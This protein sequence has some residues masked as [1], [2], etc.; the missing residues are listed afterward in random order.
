MP[1]VLLCPHGH[2][3]APDPSDPKRPELVC[4]VCGT[5]VLSDDATVVGMRPDVSAGTVLAGT[6]LQDDSGSQSASPGATVCDSNAQSP[7]QSS[8]TLLAKVG[9]ANGEQLDKTCEVSGLALGNAQSSGS[10]TLEIPGLDS[11]GPVDSQ[12]Q[13]VREPRHGHGRRQFDPSATVQ[14]A[15]PSATQFEDLSGRTQAEGAAQAQSARLEATLATPDASAEADDEATG[16]MSWGDRAASQS[17]T[18]SITIPQ[19]R[20][21][22]APKPARESIPGYEIMG[23][24]GRGGMG[25]VYKALQK[26]PNRVVAL[27]MILA[28]GHAEARDLM[29]FRI[30]AEA[31]GRLQ[32]PNIVQVYE[33]GEQD[34]LPYFSLEYVDGGSLLG[35]VAGTPQ[36]ARE[37]AKTVQALAQ[38]MDYAHRRGIMHRD[39]KPANILLT[40][41]G[42]PKITDFGLAK[43][44]DEDASQTRTGAILGTPS[45]MAPEQAA[46]KSKEVGPPADIYALGSI[47]YE[48]LTGRPPF[49]GETVLDT[50]KMVQSAEPL[51]PTRLHA[52]VPRDLETICLKALNK[53][54]HKRYESAGLLAEDL[55]RFLTGEPILARP[56][57]LWEHA[58][59]WTKRRPAVA[60]LIGV[61]TAAV[62]VVSVFGYVLASRE[63]QRAEEAIVLRNAA[64]ERRLEAEVQQNRAQEQTKLAEERRTEAESQRERADKNFQQALAA[65]DAMLTRV[66]EEKLMH[67]PRMEKVRRD[68]LQKALRFYER[69][70]E[71]QGDSLYLLLQTGRA[72]Q[73]VGD[74][75]QL[76]GEKGAA[77]KAFRAAI[78]FFT[79]LTRKLPNQAE[80][81]QEL[82]K[83][84][85]KLSLLLQEIGRRQEADETFQKS[86][87]LKTQLVARYPNTADFRY[88]VA[89]SYQN[90]ALMLQ[91]H[92]ELSGAE[93]DYRRAV[94]IFGQLASD[95][96]EVQSYQQELARTNVNYAVLMHTTNRSRK[97]EELFQKAMDVLVKLVARAP[98]NE[99]FQRELGRV[100]LN[101]GVVK[102]MNGKVV[103]AEKN[104]RAAMETF[105]K[106]AEDFPTVPEYR[107]QLAAA[108]TNL[109]NLL[110]ITNRQEEAEKLV[111]Q[112]LDLQTKLARDFPSVPGY[113]QELARA[114]NDYGILLAGTNRAYQAEDAWSRAISIQ[115]QLASEFPKEPAYRQELGRSHMNF[116]ILLAGQNHL[117]R[118]EQEYRAAVSIQEQLESEAPTV[119]AN[120]EDLLSS[121][122]NLG[123]LL[124]ALGR[125]QDAEKVLLQIAALQERQ[126]ASSPK[127]ARQENALG[128]TLSGLAKLQIEAN[129]LAEARR[130]LQ[131]AIKH[132]RIA[133]AANV[134]NTKYRQELL[135]SYL[136]LV[137]V[138]VQLDEHAEAAQA[139][140]DLRKLLPAGSPELP[141]AAALLV[142][143]ATS[144]EKD[145]KLPEPKRKELARSYNDQAM[146]LLQEAV[147]GG[148]KDVNHLKNA[149]DFRQLRSREDFKKLVA[150]L[151]AKNPV[152]PK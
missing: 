14:A 49:R 53:E 128:G 78:D 96:P 107:Q 131:D 126:L 71:T 90:R 47:L 73:R 100:Y 104:Y 146:Q 24:L 72:H 68:L 15:D 120:R 87:D 77:E 122:S 21:K 64:E 12:E 139:I 88:D 62:V 42:V 142:R 16:T 129:K 30:E 89:A 27:K 35:K 26:G 28:G 45:Y 50:I 81:M 125:R 115:K 23:E 33:V 9:R 94:E 5:A 39:L 80:I 37:A 40:S 55:R 56:T 121:Y 3:W 52:K 25:V 83:S 67:E 63:S 130:Y 145:S 91:T 143:C 75:Q 86:L 136:G 29:R 7:D 93:E 61:S 98:E 82:G 112:A 147:N 148:Y 58:W 95:S 66:G 106:L 118:A 135:T 101:F 51:P 116:G 38:A 132:Q 134:K 20:K 32:H 1:Q 17:E 13:T 138:H 6:V 41:D 48:L 137:D 144:A 60:A 19:K 4:P 119:A 34:G 43:R 65:V 99:E 141:T 113:R 117:E 2:E 36:P 70:R 69:F 124:T 110:K 85:A 103:D 152:G 59:K 18:G 46:G 105:A 57:P 8:D 44:F 102:Q 127:S 97:A 76:L 133:L 92:N 108:T 11:R 111:L 10:G 84:Y 22:A 74:I 151:E 109:S 114:L 150:S 149:E 123:S 140:A 31:V 54:P 79:D